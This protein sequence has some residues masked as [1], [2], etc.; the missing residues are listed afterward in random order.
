MSI[1]EKFKI[2]NNKIEQNKYQ[3]DLDRR[4]ESSALSSAKV[5]KYELFN[6]E[7]CLTRKRPGRKSCY[8]EKIRISSV[9]K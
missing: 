2:I 4:T 7:R 9:R 1:S 3:S 8:N 6:W 5:S